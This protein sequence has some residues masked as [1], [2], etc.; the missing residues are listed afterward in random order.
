[1][2][3]QRRIDFQT[4]L[5]NN[6]NGVGMALQTARSISDNFARGEAGPGETNVPNAYPDA[7]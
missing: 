2:R 4:D 3:L 1:M 5:R 6:Y 7:E